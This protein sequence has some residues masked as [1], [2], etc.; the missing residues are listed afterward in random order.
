MSEWLEGIDIS[1]WQGEYS[2]A[3]WDA[4]Y[5][6]DQRVAVVGSAHPGSN[7][8]AEVNL[9]R[10]EHSGLAI[11]TYIALAP[12]ASA[13]TS[14][15]V[16]RAACGATW[17]RLS[18]VAVDCEV[19]GLTKPEI[20]AAIAAIRLEGLRPVLYTAAWWWQGDFGNP[21][22]FGDL[23][24]WTANYRSPPLSDSVPIYGGWARESVMG[25]QWSGTSQLAGCTVDRNNFRKS[26]ISPQPAE[27]EDDMAP[28]C[29]VRDT[30]NGKSY[31]IV[32]GRKRHVESAAQENAYLKAGYLVRPEKM[33][34]TAE[35]DT[36]P[37]A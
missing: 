27:T 26:F 17:K 7:P 32:G 13:V 5:A 15:G 28:A 36:I 2:Q 37:D 6:A 24:L 11:A 12:G 22:D 31:V 33:L 23:P 30:V 10:A 1:K 16:A 25:H 14:V 29:W 35:L 8:K 4:L 3:Q 34:T 9:L 19:D 20:G 18:F 21:T